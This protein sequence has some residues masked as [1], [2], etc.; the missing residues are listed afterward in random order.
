MNG[1][2]FFGVFD[3]YDAG[4]Y[5]F[6]MKGSLNDIQSNLLLLRDQ[7]WI[8]RQTRSLFFEFSVYNPNVNLFAYCNI[9][10][11]VLPTGNFIKSTR[12]EPFRLYN[13]NNL[14]VISIRICYALF[15]SFIV[16]R[17]FKELTKLI[18]Q[19]LDYFCEFWTYIEWI[20]ILVAFCSSSIYVFQQIKGRQLLENIREGVPNVNFQ[21]LS[22]T[23]DI[24]NYSLGFLVFFSTLK[25]IKIFQFSN[26]ISLVRLALSK[27][28]MELT[29]FG[30]VFILVYLSF[31]QAMF[32]LYNKQIEG[33]STM[34]K[35]METC[36]LFVMGKVDIGKMN[37]A[38]PYLTPI[39]FIAYNV[40][41]VFIVLNM[42]VSI[43][44][45]HFSAAR[46]DA[47]NRND[48]SILKYFLNQLGKLKK[49]NNKEISNENCVY[50]DIFTTLS[51][52]MDDLIQFIY[53]LKR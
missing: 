37:H 51:R 22:K 24:L 19:K 35:S 14:Y 17:I 3:N 46:K 36:F 45:D 7:N 38:E 33:F 43:I 11:E 32:I 52:R 8:D 39:I 6:N 31:A 9:L 2:T 26:S 47:K 12:F 10:F 21:L 34:I 40:S 29:C 44:G 30:L 23:T 27:C 50:E 13:S 42:F 1:I 25:F 15:C 5:A 18:K 49:N 28:F 16:F 4:G 20:I 48:I 41:V 53:K